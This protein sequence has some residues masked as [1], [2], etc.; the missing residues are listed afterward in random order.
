MKFKPSLGTLPLLFLL[1]IISMG[2]KG[3]KKTAPK[4]RI[5]RMEVDLGPMKARNVKL[6]NGEN[7]DF[8][9]VVNS[10]FYRQVMNNDHFVIANP[11]P[12]PNSDFSNLNG[13]D[14]TISS[15]STFVHESSLQNGIE[16]SF[17]DIRVLK[18]Y[19]F[20]DQLLVNK[21][22]EKAQ[23]SQ[24][25]SVQNFSLEESQEALPECLYNSPQSILDGEVISFEVTWDIGVGVGYGQDGNAL[26]GNAN[27][28]VNFNDSRLDL[29]V[30]SDDPLTKNTMAAT[31][32]LAHQQKIKFGVNFSAGLPIGLDFFYNTPVA[33]VIRKALDRGLDMVV[34][35]YESM[36]NQG[37]GWN[38]VWESR[39]IFDP[40]LVDNQTHIVF[41]S[42]YRANIK[43]GDTFTVTNLHYVW[44]NQPCTSRLKYK[45]PATTT[46]IA[47]AEVISVG[48]NVSVAVVK[49]VLREEA[50]EPGALI[51]ISKLN[52][53]APAPTKK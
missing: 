41:R 39:V 50:I 34:Y 8:A 2:N 18:E 49:N 52:E 3:C 12:N 17:Q 20:L 15:L 53:P 26:P 32:G 42:G 1:A 33:D 37:S 5:L 22:L 30:R 9:Q 31:N 51:K 35:K 46:P 19:G 45:V 16:Y 4:P 38:D 10:L 47:E 28:K 36:M 43:I 21:D 23:D 29:G 44:E 48:D 11:I 14:E 40:E 27:G 6:P 7:L 13:P 24:S 25:L